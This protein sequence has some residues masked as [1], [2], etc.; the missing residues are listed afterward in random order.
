M[1][2]V[3][4]ILEVGQ[5]HRSRSNFL[6]KMGKIIKNKSYL[7]GYFTYRLHT[8]Y[9]VQPMKAHLMIQVQMTLIERP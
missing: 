9:K 1:T 5:G 4:M 8:W 7:G 2:Q 3:L 6:L